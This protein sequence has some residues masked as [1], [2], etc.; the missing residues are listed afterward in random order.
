M[1]E[2]VFGESQD[3]AMADRTE[4]PE[5]THKMRV[6]S[7]FEKQSKSGNP[8]WELELYHEDANA[9]W[10]IR[11]YVVFSPK[12]AWKTKP[13]LRAL[14]YDVPGDNSGFTFRGDAAQCIGKWV[15][16]DVKH[17]DYEDKTYAKADRMRSTDFSA[18][19]LAEEEQ[20]PL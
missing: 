4:V 20:I 7:A 5:G 3:N 11:D 8:M 6:S 17:E 14:G 16:V 1:V 13:Q 12:A 10:P 2:F 19:D 9:Y 15:E 18:K